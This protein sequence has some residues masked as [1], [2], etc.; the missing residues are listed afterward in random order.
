MVTGICAGF[1]HPLGDARL[2]DLQAHG[3]DLVRQDLQTDQGWT[4]DVK[5][6]VSEMDRHDLTPLYIVDEHTVGQVPVLEWVEF[7][8]EPD[9]SMS[10]AQY[11]R[12][13]QSVWPTIVGNNLTCWAGCVSNLDRDSLDWL[14]E[15]LTL[16]PEITHVSVHRYS[17]DKL[18]SATKPHTGFASRADELRLLKYLL[19]GRAFM[20]SEF[21]YYTRTVTTG[22]WIFKRTHTISPQEQRD[23]LM[24]DLNLYR[25]HGAEAAVIY[26]E[27]DGA[28][29]D[30]Y[31]LRYA[32]NPAGTVNYWKTD[33]NY[34]LPY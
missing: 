30:Q 20:V 29:T 19:Q 24:E 4:P 2:R 33:Q 34:R 26:Q 8:N 15:T 7:L 14:E 23:K 6:I 32:A 11:V 25:V 16:M 21:G 12:R 1:G 22:W 10:P 3:F 13:L 9:L 27:Q 18:Q 17:P 31:G 5:G 28:G